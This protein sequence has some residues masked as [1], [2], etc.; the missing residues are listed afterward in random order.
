MLERL[1]FV[2][3]ARLD[4]AAAR[5]EAA[6]IAATV[7]GGVSG[8]LIHTGRFFAGRLVGAPGALDA[9]VREIGATPAHEQLLIVDRHATP[10]PAGDAIVLAYAG[11]SSF[12]DRVIAPFMTGDFGKLSRAETLARLD[13]LLVRFAENRA[14]ATHK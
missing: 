9:L 13:G 12:L 5:D 3:R 14:G 2:S 7:P 11:L 1:I 8:G 4:P 6:R 10:L